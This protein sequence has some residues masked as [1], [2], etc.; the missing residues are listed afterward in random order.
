MLAHFNPQKQIILETNASDNVTVAIMSQYDNNNILRPVAFMSKKMLPAECNYEIF[1]KELLAIVKAF[2][3]WTAELGSV[4]TPT[5]IFTD[6]KNLEYFTTTKKLN[7]RQARWSELLG[8][9]NLKVVFR[10]GKQGGAGCLN[11]N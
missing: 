9:Y 6:H 3:T 5:L 1:D 11:K 4:E 8:N 2:E 10:P 7:Q